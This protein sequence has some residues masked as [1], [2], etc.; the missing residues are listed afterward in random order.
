MR[1][2][3]GFFSSGETIYFV[4]TDF[5]PLKIRVWNLDFKNWNLIFDTVYT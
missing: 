3:S 2:Y 4:V 1:I 5:N